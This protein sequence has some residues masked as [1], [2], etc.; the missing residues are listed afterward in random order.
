MMATKF[1][2]HYQSDGTYSA[3]AFL[4][5]L[6]SPWSMRLPASVHLLLKSLGCMIVGVSR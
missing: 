2:F 5:R 1:H 4:A 6:S 3:E